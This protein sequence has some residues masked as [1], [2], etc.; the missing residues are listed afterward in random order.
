VK[1]KQTLVPAFAGMTRF[2]L[3]LFSRRFRFLAPELVDET[4][5]LWLFGFQSGPVFQIQ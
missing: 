4:E 1:N 3:P 2:K 5:E